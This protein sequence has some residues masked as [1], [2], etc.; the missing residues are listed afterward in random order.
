MAI[1]N[2]SFELDARRS[3]RAGCN[4]TITAVEY[5]AKR[6]GAPL[7][8]NGRVV[9]AG[10]DLNARFDAASSHEDGNQTVV[11]APLETPI[12]VGKGEEWL[13]CADEN[14]VAFKG[15]TI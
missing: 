14:A 1:V 4:A 6:T 2:V 7:L 11:V 12:R 8:F 13:W 5:R 3:A 15:W 10:I 9:I